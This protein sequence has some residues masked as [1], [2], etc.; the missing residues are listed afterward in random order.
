MV[1][2]SLCSK[3]PTLLRLASDSILV[4]TMRPQT[5][6]RTLAW[7]LR[8]SAF[9]ACFVTISCTHAVTA[10]VTS[11]EGGGALEGGPPEDGEALEDGASDGATPSLVRVGPE[12]AHSFLPAT[13]TVP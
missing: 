5:R 1:P 10:P 4:V 9:A 2:G 6:P 3:R 13:L 11:A 7:I 8:S 12:A